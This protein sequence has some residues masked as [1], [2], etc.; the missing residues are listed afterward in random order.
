M[1][2]QLT[3]QKMSEVHNKEN[4]WRTKDKEF[5][6]LTEMSNAHL[7][8]A[9]QFA[10][11]K[12]EYFFHKMSEYGSMIDKL[13]AEAEKRGIVLKDRKTKFQKS[14]KVLKTAIKNVV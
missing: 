6:P 14:Q 10:Q 11:A 12:E 9:K 5:I 7:R 3:N 8:N 13:D 4:C 1:V 2:Q